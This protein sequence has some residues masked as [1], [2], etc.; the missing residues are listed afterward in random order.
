MP[1]FPTRRVFTWGSSTNYASTVL[2]LCSFTHLALDKLTCLKATRHSNHAS[3]CLALPHIVIIV[4]TP[5]STYHRPRSCKPPP[6]TEKRC[7][8]PMSSHFTRETGRPKGGPNK[9]PGR[10]AASACMKRV[11]GSQA[12]KWVTIG[13][14]PPCQ[15]PAHHPLRRWCGL[16]PLPPRAHGTLVGEMA[17]P[18]VSR[19]SI[20]NEFD[21]RDL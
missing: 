19:K 5:I 2:D 6:P 7:T 1:P 16:P 20:N 15:L 3:V 11:P 21:P 12:L 13:E 8:H 4:T 10:R 17:E 18:G 9:T 14:T